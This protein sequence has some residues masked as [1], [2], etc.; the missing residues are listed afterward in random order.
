VKARYIPVTI[1]VQEAPDKP[2][3]IREIYGKCY[4]RAGLQVR[5][6]VIRHR[7]SRASST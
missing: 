1:G 6:L 7:T 4:D 3:P 5:R 2:M